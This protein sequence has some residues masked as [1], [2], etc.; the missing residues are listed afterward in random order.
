MGGEGKSIPSSCCVPL[1]PAGSPASVSSVII[2]PV[3]FVVAIVLSKMSLKPS[4]A[5]VTSVTGSNID[6]AKSA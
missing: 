2:A 3:S 5:T 4:T 6:T 1:I